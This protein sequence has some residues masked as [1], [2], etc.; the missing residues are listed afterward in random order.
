MLWWSKQVTRRACGVRRYLPGYC[1]AMPNMESATK[2]RKNITL[3][4]TNELLLQP[5]NREDNDGLL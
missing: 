3:S 4:H 2:C 5:Q 1:Q